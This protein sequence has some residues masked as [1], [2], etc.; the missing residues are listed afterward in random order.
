MKGATLGNENVKSQKKELKCQKYFIQNSVGWLAHIKACS[1][2][3]WTHLLHNCDCYANKVLSSHK[4][5][6]QRHDTTANK[7]MSQAHS[8]SCLPRDKVTK[9]DV[10]Y[11]W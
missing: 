7:H 9:V 2:I 11:S 1:N 8:C 4:S 6:W 10:G 3:I 5:Q